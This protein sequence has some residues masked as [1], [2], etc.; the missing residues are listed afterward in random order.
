M[1]AAILSSVVLPEPEG[2][3]RHS[4]S[5]GSADRLTSRSVSASGAE[6]MADVLEGEP[7]GEGDAGGH[8]AMPDALPASLNEK[9]P[10]AGI[11]FRPPVNHL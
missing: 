5:P 8:A 11:S 3:S 9:P 1:P 4:T 7:R 6:G 2:P 10:D